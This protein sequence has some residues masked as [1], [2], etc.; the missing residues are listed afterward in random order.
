[1]KSMLLVEI[2]YL[3][4]ASTPR[5][6]LPTWLPSPFVPVSCPPPQFFAAVLQSIESTYRSREMCIKG[7]LQPLSNI[8]PVNKT[9]FGMQITLDN[10]QV[11]FG[12]WNTI[13]TV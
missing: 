12:N 6:N 2:F 7:E 1:M 9:P 11:C 10:N 5:A 4:R 8:R 13:S 3:P